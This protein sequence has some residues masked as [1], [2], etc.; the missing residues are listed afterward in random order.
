MSCGTQWATVTR[1]WNG[2]ASA[3]RTGAARRA[4]GGGGCGGA[5]GRVWAQGGGGGVREGPLPPQ[6]P[7]AD[8]GGQHLA[9]ADALGDGDEDDVADRGEGPGARQGD[10]RGR[11]GGVR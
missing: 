6:R 5:W 1:G 7:G 9:V 11:V 8:L 4:A 2:R 3:R 10:P